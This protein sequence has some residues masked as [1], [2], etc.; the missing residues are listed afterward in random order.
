MNKFDL[1]YDY[2]EALQ[3]LNHNQSEINSLRK[4]IELCDTIP[5]TITDKQ[6]IIVNHNCVF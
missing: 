3:R 2:E 5:Q 1:L 4:L 6:V